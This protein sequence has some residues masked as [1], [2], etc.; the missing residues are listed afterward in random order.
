MHAPNTHNSMWCIVSSLCFGLTAYLTAGTWISKACAGLM[1]S[2]LLYHGFYDYKYPGKFLVGLVDRI[3]AYGI[4]AKCVYDALF[5]PMT[6]RLFSGWMF[7]FYVVYT[8]HIANNSHCAQYGYQWHSTIHIA[9]AY[10]AWVMYKE[11][12]QWDV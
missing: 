5:L 2:S 10:C 4:G 12:Y 3:L 1:C 6:F 7:L 11:R 9:C 8:Y